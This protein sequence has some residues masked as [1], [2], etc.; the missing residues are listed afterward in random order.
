MKNSI[1]LLISQIKEALVD[2]DYYF[3]ENISMSHLSGRPIFNAKFKR[4]S[5]GAITYTNE[6][7]TYW[8]KSVA[9]LVSNRDML[10]KTLYKASVL[11]DNIRFDSKRMND[12]M[13]NHYDQYA[14]KAFSGCFGDAVSAFNLDFD[15]TVNHIH[16]HDDN[17]Q[18]SDHE[19][20]IDGVNFKDI[21]NNNLNPF[22]AAL[23]MQELFSHFDMLM[24][25]LKEDTGFLWRLLK[26][27]EQSS[28]DY[29][30]NKL[31]QIHESELEKTLTLFLEDLKKFD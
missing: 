2:S 12:S 15:I 29:F 16:E 9:A 6:N 1:I 10:C 22:P 24:Y 21:E 8:S 7:N 19:Y 26:E 28:N 30:K 20:I 27:H 14:S 18:S 4:G 13:F 5:S 3:V 31:I 17:Y 25:L 11:I 23:F